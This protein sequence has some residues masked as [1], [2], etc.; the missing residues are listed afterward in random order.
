MLILG[1]ETSSRAGSVALVDGD[2]VVSERDLHATGRRHARSLVPEIGRLFDSERL[3]FEQVDAIAVSIGPGSFTGL[4]VGV[5]CAKTLG[6]ALRK[7]VV[8]VDTFLSIAA[9]TVDP[10]PSC[11]VL[12]DALRGEVFCGRY[13]R[14]PQGWECDARPK[15][16]SLDSWKSLVEEGEL[17]TGPAVV[18]FRSQLEGLRLAFEGDA[19][20]HAT[21]IAR[22]GGELLTGT[23][24]HDF[25]KIEPNYI[26]RSA[27]EEKAGVVIETDLMGG[28]ILA[29]GE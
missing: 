29:N 10:E 28:E 6:Y 12:D 21:S 26:R 22:V 11:W 18:R 27:A 9:A 24:P 16:M 23:D 14:G 20:P 7:P 25:W 5:A 19:I 17:I 15:L 4:R 2:R 8:A 13:L 1:I 3:T